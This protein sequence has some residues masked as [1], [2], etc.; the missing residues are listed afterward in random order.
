M[1]VRLTLILPEDRY[2]LV[3]EDWVPAGF[4]LVDS[5]GFANITATPD[6]YHPAEP[7]AAGWRQWFF[8][9]PTISG[10]NVRWTSEYLPAGVYE[11]VYYMMPQQVGAYTALPAQAYQYYKPE[12]AGSSAGSVISILE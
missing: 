6:A 5:S 2:Y 3:V 1:E 10:Q 4:E 12:V 9:T 7:I 8:N 11:L